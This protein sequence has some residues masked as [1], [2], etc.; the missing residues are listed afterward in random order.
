[1]TQRDT[2]TLPKAELHVHAEGTLEPEM[3]FA[4]AAKNGVALPY[5]DIDDLRS[6]YSFSNL[7]EFLDLYYACTAVLVTRDDFRD[8]AAAYLERAAH[9]GVRHVELFFDPQAHTA[10][11]VAIDDVLDGLLDAFRQAEAD[12][13]IT[14]GLILCVMRHLPADDAMA[15]LESVA[16]RAGDLLAIGMDSSEVGFPAAPFG[17]VYARAQELGLHAVAHAGEEGDP[18]YVWSALDDLRVQ[19]VDHGIRSLEDPALVERLVADGITLTVCPLS[20]V[21][22]AVTP[23]LADHPLPRMLELGVLATVNSDDPAY[24]G[25]YIDDNF[26]AVRTSL[27]LDDAALA[28]LAR[29]SITGAFASADR[30]AELLAGVDAWLDAPQ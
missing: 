7:Q 8:L 12:H 26:R 27:G 10:R 22:L 6:R 14:G 24:F 21:R 30:K 5:A 9:D 29:N 17:A 11:G 13:G 2:R 16:H 23:D 1:M 15:T 18:S 28:S 25:G 4:L 19:R 3:V 20:N